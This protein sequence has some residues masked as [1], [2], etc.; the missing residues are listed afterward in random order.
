M[1]HERDGYQIIEKTQK[2]DNGQQYLKLNANL[3]NK[4]KK[5]ARI[6]FNNG[7]EELGSA[8]VELLRKS[9][10]V[11]DLSTGTGTYYPD[12]VSY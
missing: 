8:P 5:T 12:G 6:Y 9:D 2:N 11:L 4:C 1:R 10:V 3:W 7:N